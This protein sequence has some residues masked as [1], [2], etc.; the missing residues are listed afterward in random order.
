V[1]VGIEVMKRIGG[2]LEYASKCDATKKMGIYQVMITQIRT[3]NEEG[4]TKN[5]TVD[6][7]SMPRYTG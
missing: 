1:K 4:G 3:T 2:D 6:S 5:R 7:Y